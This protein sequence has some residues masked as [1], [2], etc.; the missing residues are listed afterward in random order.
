[1]EKMFIKFQ[2][3]FVNLQAVSYVETTEDGGMIVELMTRDLPVR[4][5]AAETAE[6]QQVLARFSFQTRTEERAMT[7]GS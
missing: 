2:N 3:R 6:F 1:M 7:P 5:D 4:L